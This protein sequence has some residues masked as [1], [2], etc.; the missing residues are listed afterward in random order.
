MSSQ[1]VA[2]V[3][4]RH[5]RVV[6]AQASIVRS[7]LADRTAS[8]SIPHPTGSRYRQSNHSRNGKRWTTRRFA[9][10]RHVTGSV[11]L[12]TRP[13]GE[14]RRSDGVLSSGVRRTDASP[15]R[16]A[17]GEDH[18]IVSMQPGPPHHLQADCVPNGRAGSGNPPG[19]RTARHR[20]ILASPI[21]WV[22]IRQANPDAKSTAISFA[23]VP[24]A[25]LDRVSASGAEGYRFE[26]CR[27]YSRP[28]PHS[29]ESPPWRLGCFR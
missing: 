3:G 14:P 1:H 22:T 25:Q 27:G 13:V 26:S 9:G 10:S 6:V 4:G 16:R 12:A 20:P 19:R 23:P 21:G 15:P 11:R 29:A 5:E 17:P 8:V 7:A 18:C 24:V 2:V 28:C